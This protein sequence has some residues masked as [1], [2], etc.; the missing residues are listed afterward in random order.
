M[1]SLKQGVKISGV[2]PEIVLCI[3]I[4]ASIY[5]TYGK[6]CVVTSVKDGKHKDNSLHYDG[7][8]VDFRTKHLDN[9]NKILIVRL[10][11][12]ALGEE[13]DVIL[14]SL[15]LDNEHLHVEFQPKE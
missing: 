11:T 12:E 1:I 15:G 8:A 3:N 4:V 2:K 9:D 14:E 13:F 7:Y 10:I 5:N 6:D